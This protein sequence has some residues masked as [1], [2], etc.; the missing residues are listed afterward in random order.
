MPADALH[1]GLPGI[2]YR[3]EL[4]PDDFI[5]CLHVSRNGVVWAGSREGLYRLDDDV[6]KLIMPGI[7]VSRIEE[8]A[9][10]RLL[11]ATS[12]GFFEWDGVRGVL[13]D[14]VAVQLGVKASEIY[15]VFEDSH[16]VRWVLHGERRRAHPGRLDREGATLAG[17]HPDLP[18]SRRSA[19]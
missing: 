9:D 10:G 14:E 5:L 13:Q 8:A 18:G 11:V 15:D 2:H 17:G 7:E 12:Q 16:G 1:L 19:R 4:S 3:I 6:L